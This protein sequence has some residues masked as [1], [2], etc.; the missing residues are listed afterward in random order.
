MPI[1]CF[2]NK[3]NIND[4]IEEISFAFV[5]NYDDNYHLK[6]QNHNPNYFD[7]GDFR[8]KIENAIKELDYNIL[9]EYDNKNND[10][11]YLAILDYFHDKIPELYSL[12][13]ISESGD[14]I[15][16]VSELK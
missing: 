2:K 7:C 16:Y 12:K 1:I 6:L 10:I 13:F 3:L 14:S 9:K 15:Y 5:C 8:I 4:Y 11:R